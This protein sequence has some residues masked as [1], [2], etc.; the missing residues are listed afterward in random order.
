MDVEKDNQFLENAKLNREKQIFKEDKK[1]KKMRGIV[2]RKKKR[3]KTES[4]NQKM[5]TKLFKSRARTKE[6][7]FSQ[8]KKG[9]T[10]PPEE[11]VNSFFSIVSMSDKKN[12]LISLGKMYISGDMYMNVL[13]Q[14]METLLITNDKLT[15]LLLYYLNNTEENPIILNSSEISRVRY[16]SKEIM[17]IENKNFLL[18]EAYHIEDFLTNASA[19]NIDFP[20]GQIQYNSEFKEFSMCDRTYCYSQNTYSIRGIKYDNSYFIWAKDLKRQP[21]EIRN[22]LHSSEILLHD[23]ENRLTKG[24]HTIKRGVGY[25]IVDSGSNVTD[26]CPSY[27][28]FYKPIVF[29]TLYTLK[30]NPGLIIETLYDNRTNRG[31]RLPPEIFTFENIHQSMQ[32]FRVLGSF[33]DQYNALL[34]YYDAYT[35]VKDDINNVK[36]EY[37]DFYKIC[38]EYYDLFSK[39]VNYDTLKK[40]YDHIGAFIG[41]SNVYRDY[42]TAEY[43][44]YVEN[45]SNMLMYIYNFNSINTNEF[46]V[47]LYNSL[48]PIVEMKVKDPTSAE[49]EIRTCGLAIYDMFLS[50]TKIILPTYRSF[51]NFGGVITGADTID[52]LKNK[53]DEL[54][55]KVYNAKLEENQIK[56]EIKKRT[57]EEKQKIIFDNVLDLL[58]A[59]RQDENKLNDVVTYIAKKYKANNKYIPNANSLFVELTNNQKNEINQELQKQLENFKQQN[60]NVDPNNI[61]RQLEQTARDKIRNDNINKFIQEY[62]KTLKDANIIKADTLEKYYNDKDLEDFDIEDEEVSLFM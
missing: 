55:K 45:N 51:L 44:S 39:N 6:E 15:N 5:L 31:T 40:V 9:K 58:E 52:V 25:Y 3:V 24:V 4:E 54:T 28:R 27:I 42:R 46:A 10:K 17:V 50:S 33:V 37:N 11:I 34:N 18:Y 14:N 16:F 12:S 23:K 38:L 43:I 61:Q 56:K 8:L 49:R 32:I 30:V 20:Q 7:V 47:M 2:G 60:I 57:D 35:K 13:K 59:Y 62:F 36:K 22:M 21:D 19:Y 1:I 48:K 53:I 29:N 41:M 26:F